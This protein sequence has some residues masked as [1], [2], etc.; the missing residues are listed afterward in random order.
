VVPIVYKAQRA[1]LQG[2]IQNTFWSFVT[3]TPL[4]MFLSPGIG[5]GVVARVPDVLPVLVVFGGMGWPW[6]LAP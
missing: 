2:L 1:L 5:A 6:I 3:I 4:L